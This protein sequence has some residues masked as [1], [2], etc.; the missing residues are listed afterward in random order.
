MPADPLTTSAASVPASPLAD[1]VGGQVPGIPAT[2]DGGHESPAALLAALHAAFGEHH[3]RGVHAKGII[4]EGT[5]VPAR[6][7][8]ELSRAAL[9]AE[10]AVRVTVRFSDFTGIPDIPDTADGA[11]PRGFGAKFHLPDGSTV[12]VVA[13]SFDGFPTATADEFAQLLRAIARS[14]P[15]APEPSALDAFLGSHPIAKTFLTTQKPAPFSYATLTYFGVNA[16]RFVDARDRGTY[17]RYRF[18]PEAGEHVLDAA[19]L[20]SK[21]PDYLVQEIASRVASTPVRFDWLAQ[22]AEPG[23]PIEDPSVAWP[24]ERRLV[25]LGTIAIKRLVSDQASA[26]RILLLLPGDVP[27]GIEVADPMLRIRDATYPLSFRERQ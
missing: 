22:V 4:L 20:K 6:E 16:F 17:V 13:H 27:P 9:F 5:F 14:G 26:D 3:A 7:A 18:V 19:H 8:R 1:I 15:G 25:R 11:N 2:S 24:K 12:D 10:A 21:G 23:D